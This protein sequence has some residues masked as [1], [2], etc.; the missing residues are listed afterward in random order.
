[1]QKMR[2]R[3]LKLAGAAVAAAGL[4]AVSKARSR[5]RARA[6]REVGTEQRSREECDALHAAKVQRIGAQL[7]Q[8]D[9]ARPVSLRKQAPPHQVPK[10]GDLRRH[11]EKIDVGDLTSILE[12][13]PVRQICVAESGV[14]FEDLVEA[15]LRHGLVPIVVPELK[16]I[17]I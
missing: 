6:R 10:R 13:D 7:R 1:M 15:T 5:R 8:H 12:I 11:D 4:I 3:T 9:P 17:T 2:N 16:T 14:M